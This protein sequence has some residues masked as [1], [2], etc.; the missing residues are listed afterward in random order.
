[1][2]THDFC[3]FACE[4]CGHGTDC[5]VRLVARHR[6]PSRSCPLISRIAC[7]S[8]LEIYD[9]RGGPLRSARAVAEEGLPYARHQ[10][11][12]VTEIPGIPDTP[13]TTRPA[14]VP[15]LGTSPLLPPCTTGSGA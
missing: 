5:Y 4:A 9:P 2:P 14:A 8:L 11:R 12:G 15:P 10:M 6:F 3:H 7:A 1:M 13:H